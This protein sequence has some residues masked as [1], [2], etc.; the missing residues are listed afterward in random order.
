MLR[1]AFTEHGVVMLSSVLNSERAIRMSI[2]VVNAFVRL[3]QI[4]EHRKDI[5]A[6][7]ER[8]ER[9]HERA[10]SVIGILVEDIDDLSR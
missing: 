8:L 2:Q 4:T 10:A 5:A 3:R 1:M 9:G 6:R 7:M